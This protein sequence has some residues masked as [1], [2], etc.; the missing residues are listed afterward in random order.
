MNV[1]SKLLPISEHLLSSS[2]RHHLNDKL[3]LPKLKFEAENEA[4]SALTVHVFGIPETAE[5]YSNFQFGIN[6][7][8]YA[9]QAPML[10][11]EIVEIVDADE[12]KKRSG[13][14]VM[15]PPP[16]PTV[17][18][19]NAWLLKQVKALLPELKA[20]LG[21]KGVN[22]QHVS[23]HGYGLSGAVAAVLGIYYSIVYEPLCIVNTVS[24]NS[25]RFTD[26][27]GQELIWKTQKFYYFCVG[28]D[29]ASPG[30]EAQRVKIPSLVRGET[31]FADPRLLFPPQ[32]WYKC[33]GRMWLYG[34]PSPGQP[35][36]IV[37]VAHAHSNVCSEQNQTNIRDVSFMLDLEQAR[38]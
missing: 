17:M 30:S 9:G 5:N 11:F 19:V 15:L 20:T 26:K 13:K 3:N 28:E 22:C 31:R 38:M 23:F 24:L 10:P 6:N 21:G 36:T 34:E 1:K 12:Q 2:E 33:T 35:K 14:N 18:N 16:P 7:G 27:A 4:G 8:P 37:P 32:K 29:Y 25:P